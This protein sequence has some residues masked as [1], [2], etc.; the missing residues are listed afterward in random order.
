MVERNQFA[1]GLARRGRVE[2]GNSGRAGRQKISLDPEYA[3]PRPRTKSQEYARAAMKTR[4]AFHS[5]LDS[6]WR[7]HRQD[8]AR[9]LAANQSDSPAAICESPRAYAWGERS[10]RRSICQP[11]GRRPGLC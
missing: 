7:V 1:R 5:M 8:L 2:H 6:T 10:G 4:T 9:N 3:R 11:A